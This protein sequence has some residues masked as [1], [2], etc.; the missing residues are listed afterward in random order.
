MFCVFMYKCANVYIH[1]CS[2]ICIYYIETPELILILPVLVQV[3]NTGILNLHICNYFFWW[4]T[5]LL[6]FLMNILT[7]ISIPV[8]DQTLSLSPH[9]ENFTKFRLSATLGYHQSSPPWADTLFT[10]SLGELVPQPFG[11]LWLIISCWISTIIGRGMSFPWYIQV[12]SF[13]HSGCD[14]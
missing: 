2:I 1:V 8:C 3:C 14:F 5:W 4:D 13:I 11:S 7:L 6:V 9:C 12:Y 10:G